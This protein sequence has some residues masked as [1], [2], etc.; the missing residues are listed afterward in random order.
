VTTTARY[1]VVALSLCGLL[2]AGRGAVEATRSGT[3]LLTSAHP[4]S[5]ART[6]QYDKLVREIAARVPA[7]SRVY[8]DPALD[9][10]WYQRLIEFA[11]LDGL[12]VTDDPRRAGYRLT[13][14]NGSELV[15][16]EIGEGA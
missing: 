2:I 4:A 14:R 10:H 7:G 3:D 12:K 8:V 9:A 15:V 1:L 6:R 16:S 11:V 13:L 5:N